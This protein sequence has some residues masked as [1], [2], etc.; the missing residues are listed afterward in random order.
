MKEVV[1]V[2]QLKAMKYIN[3][4]SLNKTIYYIHI[5]IH[6]VHTSLFSWLHTYICLSGIEKPINSC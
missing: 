2:V 5:Y 3:I 6:Y 1:L 4:I